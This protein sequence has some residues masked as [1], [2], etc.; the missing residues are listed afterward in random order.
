[1][2]LRIYSRVIF[3]DLARTVEQAV[4]RC[5]RDVSLALTDKKALIR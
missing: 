1:M 2:F 4:R 3:E 5:E